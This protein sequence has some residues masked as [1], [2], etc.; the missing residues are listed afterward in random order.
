M[1]RDAFVISATG[2][3]TFGGRNGPLGAVHT[4]PSG[5]GTAAAGRATRC[6][7]CR[8]APVRSVT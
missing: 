4:P 7:G 5:P 8:R 1:L 6:H 2:D 3:R